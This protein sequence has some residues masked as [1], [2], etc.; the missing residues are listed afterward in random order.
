M[1][2]GVVVTEVDPD[3][4]AANSGL[5][6]GD[7]V[8]EVNRVPVA[9]VGKFKEAYVKSQARTLLHIIREG[10]GLFLVTRR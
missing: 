6:P 9:N 5:R 7:L 8:L 3:S 1:K 10:R 2:S 4:P